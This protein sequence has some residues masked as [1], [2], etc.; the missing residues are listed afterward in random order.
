VWFLG[1]VSEQRSITVLDALRPPM[2]SSS[3]DMR[4]SGLGAFPPSGSP[5]VLWLGV[6]AGLQQLALAHEEV[7]SRLERWGF[8]T[9]TRPYSAHLTI[10]R[11]NSPLNASERGLLRDALETID[12]DAGSCR[13][14][15]LT[16]YRSRTSPKGAAYEPLLRVPLS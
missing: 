3:F 12:A 4:I 5:R 13:V 11:I 10:A 1:E 9:E 2:R 14:E 16:V 6:T 15:M 7:G 8:A